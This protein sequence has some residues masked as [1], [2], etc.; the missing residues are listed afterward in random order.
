MRDRF[1][2]LYGARSEAL[3]RTID[4]RIGTV[5]A[6]LTTIERSADRLLLA[7]PT[8]PVVRLPDARGFVVGDV[9][10]QGGAEAAT[11]LPRSIAG[12]AGRALVD[13]WWGRYVALIDE[14]PGGTLHI[15]RDPSGA[16]DCM[17]GTVD[18]A[19][20]VTSDVGLA[21][22][23]GLVQPRID[24]GF[25]A[26][27]L[28]YPH[29]P[30]ERTGL[31]GLRSTRPGSCDSIVNGD[32]RTAVY[33]TPWRFAAPERRLPSLE[34]AS[35]QLHAC[36]LETVQAL[37]RRFDS[38]LL[39]LSGGLDSSIV[40]GALAAGG[41]RIAALN[42]ATEAPEGDERRYAPLCRRPALPSPCRANHRAGRAR[43]PSPRAGHRV[44]APRRPFGG[45]AVGPGGARGCACG[46]PRRLFQ[47]DRRR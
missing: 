41:A 47:R 31:A 11:E 19:L 2:A 42:I 45:P 13:A 20:L 4:A 14:G 8:L 25:A 23:L 46:W 35:E 39:E 38:I 10:R 24:W 30:L 3:E 37:A 34:I 6:G 26:H 33:W 9:F 36:I 28:A 5:D 44:G 7:H 1:L 22:G 40:A 29:L 21:V 16:I 15:L 27:F 17:Q 32:V 43:R 18:G 12:S